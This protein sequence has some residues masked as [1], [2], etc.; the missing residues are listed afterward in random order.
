MVLLCS[1]GGCTNVLLFLLGIR[2]VKADMSMY[3]EIGTHGEMA[4][5]VAG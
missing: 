4:V 2:N 3:R 1:Q 5:A